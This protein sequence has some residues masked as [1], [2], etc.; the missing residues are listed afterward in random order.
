VNAR[1]TREVLAGED[2]PRRKIVALNA[3]LAIVA[4]G[5]AEAIR[6]G[7]R[8]AEE[9]L[10]SGAALGKLEALVEMTRN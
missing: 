4:G 2:G 7:L 5:K 10:D 6:E 8:K 9:C 1:I 3:A